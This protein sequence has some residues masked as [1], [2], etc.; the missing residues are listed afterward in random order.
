MEVTVIRLSRPLLI[1]TAKNKD[2]YL[3]T[4]YG[5]LIPEKYQPISQ[6]FID[7]YVRYLCGMHCYSN[8]DNFF[9]ISFDLRGVPDWVD[10]KGNIHPNQDAWVDKIGEKC[11]KKLKLSYSVIPLDIEK[12]EY[13]KYLNEENLI[14]DETFY[15]D[16]ER[17][18]PKKEPYWGEE[19]PF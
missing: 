18:L 1:N 2:D 17:Y 5:F 4:V 3:Q 14:V 6:R 7:D 11:M 10:K 19:L 8:G 9:T 15:Y 16:L 12:D 13:D